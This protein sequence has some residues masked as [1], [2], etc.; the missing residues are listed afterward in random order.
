MLAVV[1][2]PSFKLGSMPA[3]A[4][5]AGGL[6]AGIA[7]AAAA[8]G[9]EVQLIGKVGDDPAGDAVLLA[10]AR[11]GVG[12]RPGHERWRTHDGEHAISLAGAPPSPVGW[13]GGR[14]PPPEP[15]PYP[16]VAW[17]DSLGPGVSGASGVWVGSAL[18]RGVPVE[19]A[20]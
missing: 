16:G 11:G 10:L 20:A 2:S 19:L 6:A 9:A 18:E 14:Y 7:R 13:I 5:D 4:V 1:G 15:P 8:A 12:H 3:A 17:D